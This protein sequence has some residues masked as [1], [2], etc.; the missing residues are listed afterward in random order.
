MTIK[1]NH[2]YTQQSTNSTIET[3]TEKKIPKIDLKGTVICK[4]K[5]CENYLYKN[6]STSL[7]GYCW[8]CG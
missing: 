4:A 1:T 8:E 7:P 5:K 2:P 3:T 6:E